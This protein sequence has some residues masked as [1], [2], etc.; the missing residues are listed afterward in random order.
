MLEFMQD[1]VPAAMTHTQDTTQ[2]LTCYPSDARYTFRYISCCV[3][4]KA[5]P[6]HVEP[7]W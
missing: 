3:R 6:D 1:I 2:S 5:V 7:Y 4:A